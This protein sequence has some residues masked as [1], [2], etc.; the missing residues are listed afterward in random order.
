M[1]QLL[2]ISTAIAG[3]ALLSAPASA[4]VK[5]DLGGYFRGYGVYSDSDEV[6]GAGADLHKYDL[7]RENEIHVTGETTLDNGLTV[8]AHTEFK[9]GNDAGANSVDETYAYFS[10]GWGRVNLGSE[11]GAAYL[12][13]VGAPSADSNVDGM[14]VYIQA[15]T[16]RQTELAG[17]A[18]DNLNTGT[19]GFDRT[20]DYQQA[21]NRQ[22]D[23]LTYLTPKFN[24]F[25]AG[26]SYAP[27]AGMNAP[28]GGVAGMNIDNDGLSTAKDL[29]E[30]GAR[31][32]GEYQ[33]FGLSLGGGYSTDNMERSPTTA[34]FVAQAA[35]DYYFVDGT[36]SWNLGA[37][38]AYSGF[39]LGGA[40]LR[41]ETERRTQTDTVADLAAGLKTGDVTRD[42]WVVGLGYDNGPY[43]VGASWLNQQVDF[44]ALAIGANADNIAATKYESNKYTVGA[45]YTFGPGMTF[46]G[47]VAWGDFDA[48]DAT[49]IA[50]EDNDFTQV[51]VGTDIQF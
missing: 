4:A 30:V 47:A 37:N 38:V 12:L 17:E 13:Q 18:G 49:P 35:Q 20:F 33:G 34:E 6:G 51:T 31:W 16:K 1:K 11:D 45:G 3:V 21:D 7:R 8:G 24:G 26:V 41:Q 22:T 5:L 44:D 42:T 9:I 50:A 36:D 32:D 48:T 25:Q 23:R 10:G 19:W 40:F 27:E 28:A 29:W 2:L 15:L 43:H 46:R 14:R 39:T